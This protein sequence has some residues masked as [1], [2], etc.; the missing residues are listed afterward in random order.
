MSNILSL[1]EYIEKKLETN[2]DIMEK[3]KEGFKMIR[4]EIPPKL[5]D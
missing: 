5:E 1:E 2:A 4:E 3:V